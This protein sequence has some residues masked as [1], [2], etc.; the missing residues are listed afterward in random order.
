MK[1][2]KVLGLKNYRGIYDKEENL[3]LVDFGHGILTAVMTSFHEAI[4]KI[5]DILK[6]EDALDFFDSLFFLYIAKGEL[7]PLK[8]LEC[9]EVEYLDKNG[10]PYRMVKVDG[11][12][13]RVDYDAWELEAMKKEKKE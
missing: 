8:L 6:I 9:N 12:W 10:T 5:I 3:I 1:Y 2:V 11:E 13:I 4:H 7:P